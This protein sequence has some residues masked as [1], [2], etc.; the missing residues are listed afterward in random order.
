MFLVV[1][2][3]SG[4]HPLL[5]GGRLGILAVNRGSQSSF[6]SLEV[7]E[8]N[9]VVVYSCTGD[10]CVFQ[11]LV[12][13]D[14]VFV[15]G[16]VLSIVHVLEFDSGVE[17]LVDLLECFGELFLEV[18]PS[19]VGSCVIF[20]EFGTAPDF[21]LAAAMGDD[22]SDLLFVRH[23]RLLC[24]IHLAILEEVG[25]LA[26]AIVFGWCCCVRF[27]IVQSLQGINEILEGD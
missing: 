18:S 11:Q 17:L 24:K 8:N 12:E 3:R 26:I 27:L 23:V 14:I 13:F 15:N 22:E 25:R 16:V 5:E 10:A 7:V 6:E 21:G 20:G 2:L 4:L 19:R 9:G 1:D